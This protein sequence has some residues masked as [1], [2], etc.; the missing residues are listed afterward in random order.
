MYS[1]AKEPA[2]DLVAAKKE[3]DDQVEAKKKEAK[4]FEAKMRQKASTVGN[5]VGK[6]VPVSLTEV[7][8]TVCWTRHA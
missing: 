7:S 3:I 2:D 1:Q 5:I 6:N 8:D 4:E